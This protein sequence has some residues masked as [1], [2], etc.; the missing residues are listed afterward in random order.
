MIYIILQIVLLIIA[1]L[2]GSIPWALIIGKLVKGIDI[3]EYGSKNMGATNTLRVLGV[4]WGILVFVLDALKGAIIVAIMKYNFFNFDY[5]LFS[6]VINPLFYGIAAFLGHIFPIYTS[7][8]GG[9]G[10]STATG[11]ILAYAPILFVGGLIV[12]IIVFLITRYVSLSSCSAAITAFIISLFIRPFDWY[13]VILAGIL[14]ILINVK[15]IA[16]YKR[17]FHHQENK[18]DFKQIKK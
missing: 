13:L 11:V 8:K 2:F 12:F 3:R 16:N 4:K 10:V 18:I 5:T 1:Y 7:F 14:T 17:I 9:K 15:H 6:F